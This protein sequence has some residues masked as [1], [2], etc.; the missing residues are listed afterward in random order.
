MTNRNH[1]PTF[2]VGWIGQIN[3]QFWIDPVNLGEEINKYRFYQVWQQECLHLNPL[4]TFSFST[5]L[6]GWEGA[7][8]G[9][10]H[11]HVRAR[12]TVQGRPNI[13]L[14]VDVSE[15]NWLYYINRKVFLVAAVL[16]CWLYHKQK[17]LKMV[18]KEYFKYIP[19]GRKE[20]PACFGARESKASPSS[21]EKS[22]PDWPAW[23]AW[24]ACL[25]WPALNKIW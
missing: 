10:H 2:T 23:P 8:M 19:K 24:P 4:S 7:A 1:Q 12:P 13:Y 18:A 21:G 15:W 22:N 16:F 11:S 6:H 14:C 9:T 17:S 5:S 3:G 20:A 25:A